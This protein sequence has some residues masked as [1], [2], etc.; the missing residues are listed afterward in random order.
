MNVR[1]KKIVEE[2]KI[3]IVYD[4]CLE[5]SGHYVAIINTIVINS[6]LNDYEKEKVLLHEL[7]HAAMHQDNYKLYKLTFSLH[8]KMESEAEDYMISNFIEEYNYQYNYSM[9]LEEFGVGMGY[10]TKYQ[11]FI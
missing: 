7:G 8:S 1:T 2:L 4:D 9:M 5:S 10:D 3:S 11:R 6:N